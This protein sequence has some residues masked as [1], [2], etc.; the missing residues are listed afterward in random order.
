ME[1]IDTPQAAL[2]AFFRDMAAAEAACDKASCLA[3]KGKMSY[4]KAHAIGRTHLLK[5]FQAHCFLRA[6]PKRIA[7]L[8]WGHPSVYLRE[9]I[10]EVVE[11]GNKATII[12]EDA[13]MRFYVMKHKYSLVK[14]DGKWKVLDNRK[15]LTRSTGKWE[16][17]DL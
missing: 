1:V 4:D 9:E 7:G 5:V 11:A 12:T 14:K 6:M 3:D 2:R 13:S 8:H 16:A 17:E 15:W 10:K